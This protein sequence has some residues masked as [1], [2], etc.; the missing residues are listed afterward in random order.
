MS[1]GGYKTVTK[2]TELTTHLIQYDISSCSVLVL[3]T[4]NYKFL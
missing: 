4:S 2:E 1:A 3:I